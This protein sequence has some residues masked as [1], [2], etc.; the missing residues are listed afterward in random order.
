MTT[1]ACPSRPPTTSGTNSP[2]SPARTT[3]REGGFAPTN[4]FLGAAAG[5]ERGGPLVEGSVVGYVGDT[6]S[7]G[8]VHLHLEVR[9]VRDGV[10]LA[11]T[12]PERLV[13]NEISIV[14]DPRNVLPLWSP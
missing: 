4:R 2:R 14:C 12:P 11:K 13:A 1:C 7:E 5:V 10:D 9:R 8:V 3:T 6:G